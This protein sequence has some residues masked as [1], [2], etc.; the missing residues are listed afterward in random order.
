[1]KRALTFIL[2]AFMIC[3][4]TVC[5][6]VSQNSQNTT[7]N[8]SLLGDATLTGDHGSITETGNISLKEAL[9][10]LYSSVNPDFPGAEET[11][12]HVAAK[13]SE[14]QIANIAG[15]GVNR[16]GN[17]DSWIFGVKYGENTTLL[18]LGSSGLK[19]VVWPGPFPDS[20]IR[21]DDV[22]MPSEILEKQAGYTDEMFDRSYDDRLYIILEDGVYYITPEQ[23]DD[24]KGVQID[25]YTGEVIN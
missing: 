24:I 14:I 8:I 19:E 16:Y 2:A 25:A 5:A 23:S 13:D 7:Q 21:T 9:D 10:K 12:Y 4:C 20:A 18:Y 3:F 17:A 22:M 15:A 6:C 11:G 1:M